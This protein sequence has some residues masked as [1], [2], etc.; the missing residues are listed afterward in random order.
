MAEYVENRPRATDYGLRIEELQ[1]SLRECE[2]KRSEL[3]K[4]LYSSSDVNLCHLKYMKLKHSLEQLCEK[5]TKAR[6]RNQSYLQE[7]ERLETHLHALISNTRTLQHKQMLQVSRQ[8]EINT[9]RDMSERMYHPATI[10]MGR[11]MSA[12]SSIEHCLTQKKSPQPTKSFSISDPH[13]V[14][15]AAINSTVT[16]SCVVPSNSD[17]QCLNK[18]DK[19][20]GKTSF[21]ISQ[22]MPVT[23]IESSQDG[24]THRIEIDKTESGSKHSLESR[25][26]AQLSSL[27]LERLSPGNRAEDLQN[28]N[29]RN[30]VEESLMYESLVPNE[31]RFTHT[32]PSGYSPDAC[33]YINKQPSDKH[34]ACENLAVD[35]VQ[36]YHSIQ[37]QEDHEFGDHGDSSS[38]LTVSFSD[39]DISDAE[40]HGLKERKP[41]PTIT[42]N[43]K[44]EEG[45]ITASK[46]TLDLN[47]KSATG[48]NLSEDSSAVSTIS[49]NNLSDRGFFHL[50]QS[51]EVMIVQMEPHH[52][53]VYNNT[54]INQ[55][56]LD[57]LISLCNQLKT[58]NVEDL[59]ACSAL[60]LYQLQKLLKSPLTTCT[61]SKK[62][63][64]D[65]KSDTDEKRAFSKSLE[66]RV[67]DHISLLKEH[68]IFNERDLPKCLSTIWMWNNKPHQAMAGFVEDGKDVSSSQS[69]VSLGT[70]PLKTRQAE[71]DLHG[72]LRY[73]NENSRQQVNSNWT[74]ATA[75]DLQNLQQDPQHQEEEDDEEEISDVSELEIPGLAAGDT[76][77]RTKTNNKPGSDASLSSSEKTSMSSKEKTNKIPAN[78]NSLPMSINKKSKAFWGESEDSSSEIEAILRPKNQTGE[79]DDFD[80]FFD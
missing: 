53:H 38:D 24:R 13:S 44:Q 45:V 1:R 36:D 8:A 33:D 72:S 18:P 35:K 3:E 9:G 21:Q 77:F 64:K 43:P 29:P 20:D 17:I 57:H 5:E 76:N 7:F 48:Q 37:N 32:S 2:K 19:I 14:R 65:C 71:H 15:Q 10:F 42:T 52:V 4:K 31:E 46:G 23:S 25:Q 16:D 74:D 30:K 41:Q 50:L 75:Q 79:T 54:D 67:L 27:S 39:S 12:N 58:L 22:K 55:A 78:I 40:P 80:D 51:I 62:N 34:S 59:E 26:S 11:Q 66:E 69:C 47:S 70:T 60:V 61:S 56:K 6:V 73:K 28:D 68:R 63:P 49:R